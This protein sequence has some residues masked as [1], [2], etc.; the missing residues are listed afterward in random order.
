MT[1][2][3]IRRGTASGWTSADPTLAAGEAG[4]ETDT[5]KLKIGDAS[6][7]WTSLAYFLQP[8]QFIVLSKSVTVNQNVGGANGTEVFWTWDGSRYKDAAFTHSTSTNSERVTVGAG[9][10]YEVTFIGS[11]MQTGGAR[12]T[13]QGIYKVNGGSTLRGGSLRNYSRG[14]G[15]GNITAGIIYTLELSASDYIEVG[16]RVEDA[17]GTYTINTS[18]AEINDEA[19]MFQIKRLA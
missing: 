19:H 8:Q 5:G 13:L 17:D 1:T 3:Q 18:G 12:T 11:A 2:I 9:G 7:A 15:Y 16:T 4:Y 6:T 14:S 10:W